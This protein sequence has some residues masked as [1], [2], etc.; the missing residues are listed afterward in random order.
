MISI[1]DTDEAW[2]GE[3]SD[4]HPDLYEIIHAVGCVNGDKHKVYLIYMAMRVLEMH[5]VLKDTGSIYLHCDQTMSHPLKI[6]MDAIFKEK[7][8]ER[9]IIWNQNNVSGCKASAE[10]WIRDHDTILFYSKGDKFFK[11][12]Y[13]PYS[14]KYLKRFK[15]KDK[16]G[17]YRMQRKKKKQYLKDS[18]GLLVGDVWKISKAL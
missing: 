15:H 11:K 3:L 6:V 8:F 14:E 5:R 18:K 4:K 13:L 10:N 2:W 1:S 12:Q 17:F 7:N 16:N 9:E